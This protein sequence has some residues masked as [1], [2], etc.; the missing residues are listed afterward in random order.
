MPMAYYNGKISDESEVSISPTN[1]GFLFGDGVFDSLKSIQGRIVS[2]SA[3]YQRLLNSCRRVMI[4][5]PFTATDLRHT[6][7]ELLKKNKLQDA[8]I[9]ITISRGESEPGGFGYSG[10]IKPSCLIQIRESKKIPEQLYSK[11]VAIGFV[12]FVPSN[13]GI[14]SL[15]MIHHV[16]AKQDALNDSIFENIFCDAFENVYEGSSTNIFIIKDSAVI[17]PPLEK[18]VLPGTTRERVIY[19][20]RHMGIPVNESFFSKRDVLN[21]DECFLTNTTIEILPAVKAANQV[22]GKGC[23]GPHTLTL[24]QAFKQTRIEILE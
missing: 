18:G 11:G 16:L 3:H 12:N 8:Y 4:P 7:D 1:R 21:A 14:K 23:P 2:F 5:I 15:S 13:F 9:R 19:L 17:T 20:C 24:Q 10:S 6:L 22:I